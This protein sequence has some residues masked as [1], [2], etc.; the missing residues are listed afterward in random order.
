[1]GDG[2][3]KVNEGRRRRRKLK[4]EGVEGEDGEREKSLGREWTVR[5]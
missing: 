1:L 3:K 4:S 2:V 5:S